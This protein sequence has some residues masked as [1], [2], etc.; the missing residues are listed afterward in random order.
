MERINRR[1]FLAGVSGVALAALAGCTDAAESDYRV[2]SIEEPAKSAII[3]RGLDDLPPTHVF[4]VE[5]DTEFPEHGE[6]NHV[7]IMEGESIISGEEYDGESSV[8]IEVSDGELPDDE[9][10]FVCDDGDEQYAE[11]VFVSD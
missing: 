8:E 9:L 4:T 3:T 10:R 11:V 2:A 5:L 1:R 7:F 6:P